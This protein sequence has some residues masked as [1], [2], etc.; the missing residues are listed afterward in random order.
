[1]TDTAA[2]LKSLRD[3]ASG[4]PRLYIPGGPAEP[5]FLADA[6]RTDPAL[7]DGVTFLGHWLPGINH[8]DWAG[9]H[10]NAAAEGTF[11]YSDHR[12]S[13]EA[14]RFRLLPLHYSEA[15]DWL[16]SVPLDAAFIPVSAPDARGNVSLSLGTDMSP[17]I[18]G[19]PDVRLIA[20]VRRDLPA[21]PA[22]PHLP[23]RAFAETI[24]D[25]S[26]LIT[27]L[28]PPPSDETRAIA[29]HAATLLAD[30][31]TVQSG[32]GSVQ[33]IAMAAAAHHRNMRI[34]T[35]MVSDPLLA[36]MEAGAISASPGAI[37][38]GTAIG[39]PPL[40]ERTAT[41][42][43]FSFQPV[44]VTHSVLVIAGI[45]RF[46]AINGG[47]EVDLFGQVNSEWVNGR[48]VASTGGLGNFVR[49]ANLSA[50]G[51]NIIALPATARGGERS[52]IVARL[53]SPTITLPRSETGYVVTEHGVADLATADIDQRADRLIAIAAPPFRDQLA[54]EWAAL[55]AGL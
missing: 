35:G 23:P 49:G 45:P 18:T 14:G 21:P 34:H 19:R 25:A 50:G 2:L 16:K 8:T 33:Q 9:L 3:A 39:T 15:F 42:P 55:R 7:A 36:A 11:L 6:F 38:T 20:V 37:L 47:V 32:I 22:S 48:Q 46:A 28:D 40:Y 27:L 29:A 4:A 10:P 17:A 12:R 44:S 41:D 26:P 54:N 5:T 31:Y 24:E 1:V 51:R 30:G 52:R 43:R 53:A 13:F